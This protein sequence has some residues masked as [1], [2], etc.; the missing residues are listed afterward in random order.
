MG[1]QEPFRTWRIVRSWE[2]VNEPMARF[3]LESGWA[4]AHRRGRGQ[5]SVFDTLGEEGRVGTVSAHQDSIGAISF[6][7]TK[8][9]VVPIPRYRRFEDT[10]HRVRPRRA[11]VGSSAE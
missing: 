7:P 6:H 10:G 11:W 8:P 5:V 9:Y 1:P 2:V 4:S 3:R